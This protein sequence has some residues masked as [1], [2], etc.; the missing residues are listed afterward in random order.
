MI[1]CAVCEVFFEKPKHGTAKSLPRSIR[2]TG[3]CCS[4][5]CRDQKE[6]AAARFTVKCLECQ[7]EFVTIGKSSTLKCRSCIARSIFKN[8]CKSDSEN[9]NWRGGHRNWVPGRFGIDKD[10]LSW[11]KQRKLAIERDQ[12]KCQDP[13]CTTP[14]LRLCVH[15]VVPYRV[16]MS[17]ALENLLCLCDGC[18]ASWDAE[19]HEKW[20]GQCVQRTIDKIPVKIP[21]L[22]CSLHRSRYLMVD[23]RCRSCVRKEALK[24]R[25]K[26]ILEARQQGLSLQAIAK[27][28]GLK[29]H[30]AVMAVLKKQLDFEFLLAPGHIPHFQFPAQAPVPVL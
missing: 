8:F 26:K 17:H 13:E 5:R 22:Q 11:K 3:E 6:T 25:D 29:S 1:R 28:F 15:H 23:G 18:H 7:A 27:I 12:A 21:C 4:G 16:S 9:N 14:T 19:V 10:G 2:P 20:G 30:T 24:E